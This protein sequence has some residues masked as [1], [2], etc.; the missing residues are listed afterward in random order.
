[1]TDQPDPSAFSVLE[2]PNEYKV[3][4]KVSGEVT[5]TVEADSVDAARAKVEAMA[6]SHPEE[7]EVYEPEEIEVEY[8]YKTP[9]MYRVTREGQ[10]MQVSR[11]EAG[12]MPR[13]PDPKH[14]F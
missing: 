9:P 10:S 11:L 13:D 2:K 3:R 14:G 12:D 4:C 7:F 5:I 6:E 8:A 1:M